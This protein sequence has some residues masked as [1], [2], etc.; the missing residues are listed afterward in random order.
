MG[1]LLFVVVQK[2]IYLSMSQIFFFLGLF[3]VQVSA[4]RLNKM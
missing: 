2:C 3:L 1:K 4:I